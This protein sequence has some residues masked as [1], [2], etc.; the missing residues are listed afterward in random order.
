MTGI[1]IFLILHGFVHS[2]LAAAPIPND[3]K[4]KPGDFFTDPSR[5]RLLS[6]MGFSASAIRAAGIFLTVLATLGFI[7]AGLGILG[8][9]GLE[10]VWRG[11]TL[12][13]AGFSLLLLALF[14]HPWLVVG[15]LINL[16][17]LVSLLLAGWPAPALIGS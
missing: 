5:T 10:T 17:I 16:G 7:A 15:V 12:L 1:G 3:P 8:M 2:G 6:G 14:W 4:S 13:S 11:L 9:P